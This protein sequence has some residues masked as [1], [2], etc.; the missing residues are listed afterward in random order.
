MSIEQVKDILDHLRT[1]HEQLQDYYQNLSKT[2]C[3]ARFQLLME[4]LSKNE[5]T[6]Q[7]HINRL[8]EET[9]EST[10][11]T[12]FNFSPDKNRWDLIKGIQIDKDSEIKDV[13]DR[14]LDLDDAFTAILDE[15]IAN[16]SS[17]HARGLFIEMRDNSCKLRKRMV[18]DVMMLEEC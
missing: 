14:L 10:L 7:E 13:I 3:K 15:L 5:A 2:C 6:I 16:A 1:I 18:R 17:D 9:D 12:Y 4:Y 8:L 11:T